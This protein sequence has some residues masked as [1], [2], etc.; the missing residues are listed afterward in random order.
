MVALLASIM[1]SQSDVS[2]QQHTL[3]QQLA[4]LSM[5]EDSSEEERC[6]VLLDLAELVG[7]TVGLAELVHECIYPPCIYCVFHGR[8][9]ALLSAH[10]LNFTSHRVLAVVLLGQFSR[11]VVCAGSW[12]LCCLQ[13]T[14]L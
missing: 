5:R 12:C 14:C 13:T 7:R 11:C 1:S 4:A 9:R 10:L 8:P 3:E 2:S 6:A